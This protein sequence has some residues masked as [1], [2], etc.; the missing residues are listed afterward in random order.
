MSED[1][2]QFEVAVEDLVL[3]EVVEAIDDFT[4]YLDG[5]FLSEIPSFLDIGI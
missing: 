5:F 1:I 2:G 4:E 3:E